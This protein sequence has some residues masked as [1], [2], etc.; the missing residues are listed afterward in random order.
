MFIFYPS[1]HLITEA[2]RNFE[3]LRGHG[4][5]TILNRMVNPRSLA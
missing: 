5:E 1:T 2:P 4:W 3:S